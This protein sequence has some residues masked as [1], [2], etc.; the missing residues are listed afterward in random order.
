V[1]WLRRRPSARSSR[2]ILVA[3]AAGELDPV[4]LRAAIRIARAE[5]ATLVSAYL[6]VVPLDHPLDSPMVDEVG[7]ALPILE[8]IEREGNRSGV[9]VDA[10][11]ERG[12]SLRDALTRLWTEERFDR[13]VLPA[14]TGQHPGFGERDLAWALTNAPTEMLV[15]RPAPET[16]Q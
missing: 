12:R 8:A 16:T 13:I 14:S 5:E 9:P 10:R 11:M 3:F 15:L 1:R 4:V 2:R 7:E 6:I